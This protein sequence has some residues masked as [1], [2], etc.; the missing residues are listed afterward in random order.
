MS[1]TFTAP[2]ALDANRGPN[3]IMMERDEMQ[4]WPMRKLREELTKA[5]YGR[6]RWRIISDVIVEHEARTRRRIG[7][8][9]W[10]FTTV[11]ALCGAVAP[12]HQLRP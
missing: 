9:G 4:R 5:T 1:V 12:V 8:A 2:L 3:C 7:V 6:S 10:L 11:L